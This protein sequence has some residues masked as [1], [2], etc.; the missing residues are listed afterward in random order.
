[1]IGSN[2]GTGGIRAVEW[3]ITTA[4]DV[5]DNIR[6]RDE[7]GHVVIVWTCGARREFTPEDLEE[8]IGH[9]DALQEFPDVWFAGTDSHG[10]KFMARLADGELYAGDSCTDVDHAPWRALKKAAHKAVG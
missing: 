1:V 10:S 2:V 9:L 5:H 4:D 8:T 3:A 7:D 6:V